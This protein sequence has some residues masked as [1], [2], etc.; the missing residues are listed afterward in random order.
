MTSI[1]FWRIGQCA[2]IWKNLHFLHNL[3]K[4]HKI[5]TII[6]RDRCL[7]FTQNTHIW[8]I[9][10]DS[11]KIYIISQERGEIMRLNLQ[12][13]S[14]LRILIYTWRTRNRSNITVKCCFYSSCLKSFNLCSFLRNLVY[15]IRAPNRSMCIRMQKRREIMKGF[16]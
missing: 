16:M 6:I 4:K 8:Y 3:C 10:I 11:H 2:L 14:F 1:F 9:L 15:I 5:H 12:K 13:S 7:L